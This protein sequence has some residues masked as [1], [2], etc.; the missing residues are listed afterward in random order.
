MATHPSAPFC[1]LLSASL[2]KFQQAIEHF[3]LN[4]LPLGHR[5]AGLRGGTHVGWGS[6]IWW[7]TAGRVSTA[8]GAA[9]S[10]I[11]RC[12]AAH[13]TAHAAGLHGG[14][15]GGADLVGFHQSCDVVLGQVIRNN[16]IDLFGGQHILNLLNDSSDLL[17]RLSIS[18]RRRRLGL[19]F[20][21]S[22]PT[23]LGWS[24]LG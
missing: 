18:G 16:L 11:R 9:G 19:L 24:L 7:S 6:S 23:R 13:S 17:L 10:A 3:G 2:Q 12:A 20:A 8:R 21:R 14:W 1:F 22:A 4:S 5:L 15:G